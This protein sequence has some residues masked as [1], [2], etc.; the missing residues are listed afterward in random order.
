[1][2]NSNNSNVTQIYIF[3]LQTKNSKFKTVENSESAD[4][5]EIVLFSYS[6]K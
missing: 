1:M 4:N 3:A 5:F 6:L 2:N